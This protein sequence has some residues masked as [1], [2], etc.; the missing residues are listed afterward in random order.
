MRA[1]VGSIPICTRS[2]E[3]HIY[4]VSWRV[5]NPALYEQGPDNESES[6]LPTQLEDGLG[7]PQI[8]LDQDSGAERS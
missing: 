3:A 1:C 8:I 6:G 4:F 2:L 5:L 7:T